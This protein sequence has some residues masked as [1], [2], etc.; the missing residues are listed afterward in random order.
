MK[1]IR[2]SVTGLNEPRIAGHVS[3]LSELAR[4]VDG[5]LDQPATEDNLQR[6]LQLFRERQSEYLFLGIAMMAEPI[7]A[8]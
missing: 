5:L 3:S 8:E 6:F 2:Q 4:S 1:T 7:A